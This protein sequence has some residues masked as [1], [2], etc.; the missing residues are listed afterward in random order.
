M[1]KLENCKYT[2][3]PTHVKLLGGEGRE[4]GQTDAGHLSTVMSCG[5]NYGTEQV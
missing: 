3:A 5:P 1:W 4:A 2:D